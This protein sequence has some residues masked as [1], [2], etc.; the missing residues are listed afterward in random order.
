MFHCYCLF[1]R[2]VEMVFVSEVHELYAGVC[3]LDKMADFMARNQA[4]K[5]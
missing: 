5:C 4:V 1:I 3:F 2:F